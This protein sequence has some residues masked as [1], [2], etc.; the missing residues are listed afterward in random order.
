MKQH[1]GF[2]EAMILSTYFDKDGAESLAD[3]VK[4]YNDPFPMTNIYQH[5]KRHMKGRED[6]WL[7]ALKLKERPKNPKEER[8]KE[9]VR[10]TMEVV[11]SPVSSQQEY[12]DALDDFIR[13]GRAKLGDGAM[14][15]TATTF[16]Q[17]IKAKAEIDNKTK[18]RKYDAMKQLFSFAAPKPEV[19]GEPED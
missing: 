2:S 16:I 3:V 10:Q 5:C 7:R 18:D 13:V 17:A 6:R 4:R 15:V 11:D 1:R 8:A 19:S 12:E 9:L 14:P